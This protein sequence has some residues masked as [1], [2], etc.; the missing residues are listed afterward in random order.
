MDLSNCTVLGEL[1]CGSNNLV[2]L[3]VSTTNLGDSKVNKKLICSPMETLKTLK[4]RKGWSI[5]GINNN[6]STEYIPEGTKII[7]VD[8]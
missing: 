3:D 5:Y 4:I 7:E 8:I 6:R 1:H 2:D